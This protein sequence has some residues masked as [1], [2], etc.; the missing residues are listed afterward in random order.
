MSFIPP[1]GC[2]ST[3]ITFT[4]LLNIELFV[5]EYWHIFDISSTLYGFAFSETLLPHESS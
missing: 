2:L 4:L 3:D 5:D 1:I